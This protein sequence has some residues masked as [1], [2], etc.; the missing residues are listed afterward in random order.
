M[1]PVKQRLYHL[2][3][4]KAPAQYLGKVKTRSDKHIYIFEST[5]TAGQIHII[6]EGS[7]D[8]VREENKPP[9]GQSKIVWAV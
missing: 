2:A 8:K 6:E 5:N 1:R 3:G 4:Y 7:I 9:K